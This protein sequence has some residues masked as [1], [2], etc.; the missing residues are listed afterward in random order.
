MIRTRES[1]PEQTVI[2]SLVCK[3]TFDELALLASAMS[4]IREESKDQ[5]VA[6][7]RRINLELEPRHK[8]FL[9]EY[10]KQ[11]VTAFFGEHKPDSSCKTRALPGSEF[12]YSRWYSEDDRAFLHVDWIN[13]SFVRCT[14][15]EFGIFLRDR[16]GLNH[17]TSE[18][19]SIWK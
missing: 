17:M 4:N 16:Y 19:F 7:T 3:L 15:R 12:L 5:Y 1:R 18:V 10:K 9:V 8:T 11:V 6:L 13:F 14:P 2:N